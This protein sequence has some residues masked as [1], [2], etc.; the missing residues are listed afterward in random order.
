MQALALV[1]S[2]AGAVPGT[3]LDVNGA[4]TLRET[5]VSLSGT[6]ATVPS[7]VSQYR[8]YGSPGGTV[9]LSAPTTAP[10]NAGQ[11]LVIYNNTTGGYA[12]TFASVTIPNGQAQEFIYSNSTWVASGGIS[13][14]NGNYIENQTASSQ[15]AGFNISTTGQIGGNLIMGTGDGTSPS[16]NTS[17][18][19]NIIRAANAGSS[20]TTGWQPGTQRRLW[21]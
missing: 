19:Y 2:G 20:S 4:I 8:I 16:G 10:P 15:T 13:T 17:G 1:Y 14:G 9:T 11:T 6:T 21:L 18:T 3:E 7:N 5:A 12:A